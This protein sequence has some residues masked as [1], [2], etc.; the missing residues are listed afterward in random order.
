MATRESDF[1]GLCEAFLQLKT[2]EECRKFLLDLCTPAEIVALA[3]RWKLARLLDRESLS[4]RELH[5]KTGISV[6]TIGR[7]ARFLNEEPHQGYRLILQ[8]LKGR[9]KN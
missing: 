5:E 8:R 4:Y 1:E 2:R 6:T 7:V 9:N 3:E